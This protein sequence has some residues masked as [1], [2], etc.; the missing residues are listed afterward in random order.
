MNRIKRKNQGYKERSML[1]LKG[2]FSQF[3]KRRLMLVKRGELFWRGGGWPFFVQKKKEG[4][5]LLACKERATESNQKR[6][7][8]FDNSKKGR[9]LLGWLWL[10]ENKERKDRKGRAYVKRRE[11]R[12]YVFFCL[13]FGIFLFFRGERRPYR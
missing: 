1:K 9:K 4:S 8:D 7:R 11:V 5:L 3:L 10:N 12:I 2:A 6:K 13:H